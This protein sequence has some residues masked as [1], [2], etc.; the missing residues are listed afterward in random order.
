METG[1]KKYWKLFQTTFVISACTFGG[2][3]VI[4]SMLQKEFVENCIG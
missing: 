2:G 4:I 3:A 1:W